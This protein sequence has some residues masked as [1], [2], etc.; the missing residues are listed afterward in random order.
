MFGGG[1][2]AQPLKRSATRRGQALAGPSRFS[3]PVEIPARI[4]RLVRRRL[5]PFR[6]FMLPRGAGITTAVVFVFASIAY[7]AVKGDHLPAV[8]AGL[9]DARDALANAAGFGIEQTSILGRAQLSEADVLAFAG[10]TDRSSLLFFDV[11][12]AR[13]GLK[14]SP[15]I[16]EASVR[17]LYPG[18]LQIEIVER[19][20]FAL[21]Q[22]D[23]KVSLIAVDGTVLGPLADRRFAGLPLV[24][25]PGA[26]KKARDFLA[27]L[28]R[29][30]LR[31]QVRASILV[32]ERRWN[33]KLTNGID[34]RLPESN[35]EQ[36]LDTLA[37]L[38]RD[39][40]LLTRDITAVDLRL[41]DR[42]TV[43]LSDSAAQAR[44]EA[45]KVKKPKGKGGSA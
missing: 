17:K 36:A 28:T 25:G 8:A 16:A 6:D 13:T 37:G 34:V 40:K 2:R 42:V 15:W 1:R 26:A 4:R 14:S 39:K 20:P 29:Y 31:D 7:G 41:P 30:A 35:I 44:D 24:V 33:L 10:V 11:D 3:F 5:G 27:I 19:E 23:G 43:R 21:W 9:K 18:R 38:D 22:K 32:A 12:A 45:L